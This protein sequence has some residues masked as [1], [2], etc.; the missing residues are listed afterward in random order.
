MLISCKC[1]QRT[2]D[3]NRS[4]G[5]SN[6]QLWHHGMWTC[7][8]VRMAHACVGC[9]MMRQSMKSDA[10]PMNLF[11]MIRL[12]KMSRECSRSAN[13]WETLA[14]IQ[15]HHETGPQRIFCH[16]L[17][18]TFLLSFAECDDPPV[19]WPVL[20]SWPNIQHCE[21]GH[22][23]QRSLSS[24]FWGGDSMLAGRVM[25]HLKLRIAIRSGT[26]H[27]CHVIASGAMGMGEIGLVWSYILLE[28]I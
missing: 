6:G 19:S 18:W 3:A 5:S 17:Q 11:D 12:L 4:V 16:F 26:Q 27:P 20:A 1:L 28:A 22:C 2:K 13:S 9:G 24:K 15:S 10:I 25:F 14:C 8:R 23:F 7:T 21:T